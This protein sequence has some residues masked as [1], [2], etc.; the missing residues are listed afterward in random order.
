MNAQTTTTRN[1]YQ[2]LNDARMAF[3]AL[4]LKKSGRFPNGL[5]GYLELGDFI[6]P[7]LR[8]FNENGL[9]GLVSFF[10]GMEYLYVVNTED[11]RDSIRF[12]SPMGSASLPGC[13]EVQNI[14]A[15]QTYQRR[16]LWM[17]ALEIVERDALDALDATVGEV[18]AAPPPA[19]TPPPPRTTA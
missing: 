2:R 13:H 10:D 19:P 14:G 1:V 7:A 8:I 3:H 5:G 17:M 15:T 12:S 6:V 18:P 9:A 4:E 11:T 16:C